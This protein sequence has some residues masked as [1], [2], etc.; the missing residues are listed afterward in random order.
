MREKTH[1]GLAGQV[2]RGFHAGGLSYGYR[3]VAVDGGH[4]LEIDREQ[5]DVVRWIFA[6]YAEGSSCQ[7]LAADLN[8]RRV[9]GPRGGTW[10]VSAL[11]G[12]PAKGAGVLNN[13]LYVGRYVW[14]RS[15]WTKDPDTGKRT[16][17]TRPRAEW[18]I[19]QREE[20]RIL[21]DQAWY[22]ARARMK[23]PLKEGGRAGP[24]RAPSTLFGGILRCGICGGSMVKINARDYGCA[25]H[26]DRG[27]AVCSGLAVR[28]ADVDRALTDHLCGVL[29]S[30][31]TI[32]KIEAMV[33][34]IVAERLS[35]RSRDTVAARREALE[36]EISRL[37]EAIA[38]AGSSRALVERLVRAEAEL[39][40]LRRAT[41]GHKAELHPSSI[42]PGLRTRL[43]DLSAALRLDIVDA[44]AA[45]QEAFGTVRLLPEHLVPREDRID[46]VLGDELSD[47][48]LQ[49]AKVHVYAEFENTAERLALAVGGAKTN[50]V[51]GEGFEPSTFG[52]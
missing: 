50:L 4:R 15:K 40:A 49:G 31:G 35:S 39:E 41:A 47:V 48:A 7:R 19:E 32:A 51:A 26:K 45:M 5:G 33:R 22:A 6:R 36:R 44:R 29:S 14:N 2:Q 21:N 8:A 38:Q 17:F 34:G 18:Q 25:A 9:R 23:T 24:G 27:P 37:V 16:R 52:L 20:L 42:G 1:R 28:L 30:P 11:Y 10:S 3:S 46:E 12:S 13:E 43:A